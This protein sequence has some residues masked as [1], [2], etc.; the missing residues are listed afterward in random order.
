[1]FWVSLVFLIVRRWAICS[2]DSYPYKCINIWNYL[3]CHSTQYV[4]ERSRFSCTRWT[5]KEHVPEKKRRPSLTHGAY[6]WKLDITPKK[7]CSQ[8]ILWFYRE[9]Q[10]MTDAEM[11]GSYSWVEL[12]GHKKQ[13]HWKKSYRNQHLRKIGSYLSEA[14]L[15]EK[16]MKR[17]RDYEGHL[18]MRHPGNDELEEKS[19]YAENLCIVL[20]CVHNCF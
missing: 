19:R 1:M 8:T 2:N 9:I 11:Q 17:K 3:N 10:G 18:N 14:V 7:L 12:L 13:W 4:S 5:W 16:L 15:G 6:R 20:V